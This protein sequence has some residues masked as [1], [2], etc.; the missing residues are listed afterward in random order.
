MHRGLWRASL[1]LF[2]MLVLALSSEPKS[3]SE[4]GTTRSDGANT[5]VKRSS[6]AIALS[7][8]DDTFIAVNP[9]SN[10]VSLIDLSLKEV[11]AEIQV[12]IDPRTVS[13]DDN[14]SYAFVA[15][16]GSDSI[17]VI[18]LGCMCQLAQ[19]PVGAQPYGVLSSADGRFV[20][21]AE[22]GSGAV[23][24]LEVSSTRT[25]SR[26]LLGNKPSGLAL[27]ND[28]QTLY[29]AHLLGNYLSVIDVSRP[30][31][32]FLP[33]IQAGSFGDLNHGSGNQIPAN[34]NVETIRLWNDSNLVQAIVPAP[35]GQLAYLPHT[36]SNSGNSA[37]QFDSTVLPLVSIV[38]LEAR[39][40]LTGQQFDLGTMDPPG[41]G[42][43]F[44]AAV[45]S[46]G[47]QLWVANAA[48]NDV[49]VIDL[50]NRQLLAHIE[51]GDNPRGIIL[52][53]DDQEAYVNN[54]L[55]GTVSVLDTTSFTVTSEIA[56][57]QIPLPPLLLQGKKLFN[58][59]DDPR[60][61]NAQWIA[62]SSCHFD[63]E[64]DGRTWTFAFAGPR[65]TTS[66]L[67]M[68][69]TYPLRWS[70]E[71]DESADGEFAIRRENFGTGLIQGDMHCT[72]LPADCKLP[73]RNQGRNDDLDALAAFMDSLAMPL[74]PG[75]RQGQPLS[76]AALRGRALFLQPGLGCVACHPPPLY[77]DLQAHDVGTAT[78]NEKIG[79]TYDTP[80]L[81]GLYGSAPYFHDG[82]AVSLLDSLT[83][84][85]P[86][87]E[88]DLGAQLSASELYD[89]IQYLLS[90][91]YT[92]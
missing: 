68:I 43:P 13:I 20:Y 91:P 74:S 46:D 37:L 82:S 80:T 6:S 83:R 84:S 59:S 28:G 12:G 79:P 44:D 3:F 45:T 86:G 53:P 69:E 2:L 8:A 32:Q 89:L 49:S 66:L 81:R 64:H 16:R 77:T 61:S 22:Q 52:S 87:G 29:V 1:Y 78:D 27:S 10:S 9:D 58:S 34:M 30:Y 47:L 55:A 76:P 39:Q 51:V 36:R 40:H 25:I 48:S 33:I 19:I 24:I 42:L 56:T 4:G 63:G 11:V 70:G 26:F 90:L 38:D 62:C 17:S 57:T 73:E 50:E 14:G 60:M 85:S 65:N 92:Q 23:R 7:A 31:R 21:V 72:L 54:V 15:N 5:P 67:G 18:G 35:D 41:V 71:W 88:H 75:H